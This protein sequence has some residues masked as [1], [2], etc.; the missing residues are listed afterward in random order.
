MKKIRLT[1]K[2]GTGQYALVD[3]EIFNWI[4]QWQ[5]C[6]DKGYAVRGKS[7]KNGKQVSNIRMH[8]AIV[9]TYQSIDKSVYIDHINGN[10][11]DNRK[12][13]LRVVNQKQS[14]IN[15]PIMSGSR[16]KYKGVTYEKMKYRARI[17]PDGKAISLGS[18]D[19]P[20]EAAEAYNRAAEQYYKQYARL[21]NI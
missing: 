17:Y 10:K 19:T 21:N 6:V 3:N 20:E 14:A 2:Y 13:N 9:E 1:G 5:W 8:R 7:K 15:R 16:V 12:V 18:Y 4:N 11:L